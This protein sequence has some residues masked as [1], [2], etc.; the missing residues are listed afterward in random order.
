M[1]FAK[2]IND[3][4]LKGVSMAED[5]DK[6][7]NDVVNDS[8]SQGFMQKTRQFLNTTYGKITATVLAAIAYLAVDRTNLYSA[9]DTV[10]AQSSAH[11]ATSAHASVPDTKPE[12]SKSKT[13]EE[14]EE[15]Y[16][17]NGYV[18][19]PDLSKWAKLKPVEGKGPY[20]HIKTIDG[21]ETIE[22]GYR[23]GNTIV[24]TSELPNGKL[25]GFT[26]RDPIAKIH[27][28]YNDAENDG[29][30]EQKGKKFNISESSYGY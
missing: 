4:R 30:Y 26:V 18:K 28:F 7:I 12:Y 2:F 22:K 17:K 9:D 8:D 15:E 10:V 11:A 13:L 25:Y 19:L 27:T 16:D 6:H 23:L 1:T 29:K 20:D 3:E 5:Q 14:F 21:S 24:I